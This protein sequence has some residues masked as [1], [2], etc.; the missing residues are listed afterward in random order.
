MKIAL[1]ILNADPKRGGAERYTIDL[2]AAL[3]QRG[4]AV[5]TVDSAFLRARALTRTGQ[6]RDFDR[7]LDQHLKNNKYDVVHAMLPVKRCDI[8][9]PHAGVAAEAVQKCNA[10][11]NPRRR[12]MAAAEHRL[13]NFGDAI[14]LGLS[15]YTNAR[16]RAFYPNLPE[17]RL[18]RLFNGVD[19]RRFEPA[20]HGPRREIRGLIIANDFQRKGVP[21]AIKAVELVNDAQLKLDVVGRGD[22]ASNHPSVQFHGA[23]NQPREFYSNADFFVLPTRHDPCSLVVLEALATGLPVI[24]TRFNGACEIMT[25]GVHGYVLD[26]PND[27]NAIASAMRKML[28]PQR[29]AEMS[30]ACVA[31]RPQLSYEHHLDQLIGIY[32]KIQPARS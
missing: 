30:A 27:V 3:A 17:D 22:A 23:V 2:A 9:H 11:F 20:P 25:D 19:L 6:Y 31:L 12:A 4:H 32:E 24:S 18:L 13:V 28:D 15:N 29:R 21:Q 16:I 7:R 1:V 5:T 10:L 8:Y 14:V 26:D